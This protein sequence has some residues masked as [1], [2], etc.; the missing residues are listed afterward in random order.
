MKPTPAATDLAALEACARSEEPARVRRALVQTRARLAPSGGPRSADPGSRQARTRIADALL[1]GTFERLV[2]SSGFAAVATGG[3][4]RSE[5]APRSDIDLLLVRRDEADAT[6]LEPF[7]RALWDVGLE[8]GSAVRT[9]AQTEKALASDLSAATATLEGRFLAGDRALFA[10]LAATV[11]RFLE[12]NAARFVRAKVDETTERHAKRGGTIF[13]LAPDLKDGRGTMRDLELARLLAV[14]APHLGHESAERPATPGERSFVLEGLPGADETLARWL[15]LG[16]DR[17]RALARA[18][19][20][21]AATRAA[22]HE[23]DPGSKDQ[24]GKAVQEALAERFGYHERAGRLGVE[25]FLRDVYLAAKLVDRTL[26]LARDRI[27]R[28][29]AGGASSGPRGQRLSPGIVAT[30]AELSLEPRALEGEDGLARAAELFL[31]AQ[32][33]KREVSLAA[34][35]E[36]RRA[37]APEKADEK[38][39]EKLRSDPAVVRA[40]REILR[41]TN[42]V[43]ATLRAMHDAGFLGELLPEL[44][45][46]DCLAQADPYHAYTVDEHTLAAVAA[47]EGEPA[48]PDGGAVLPHTPEREDRIR[49]ELLHRTSRRDLLR[50]G[51]LLHDAGKIG[52]APGHTERGVALVPDVARR[53]GLALDEERHVRFLVEHHLTLSSLVEKRDVDAPATRAELLRF[54]DRSVERLDHLYLLTCADVRAVSPRAF[55][56]WKDTLLTRLY[57][58]AREEAALGP[59]A[60]RPATD[61]DVVRELVPRLPAG[62]VEAD[63]HAHLALCPSPY[64]VE[65]DPGETILHLELLR[66]LARERV[67]FRSLEEDGFDRIYFATRDRPKLF[68]AICG[69]LAACGLNIV[70]ASAFTRRDG[71]ALDRFAV[72]P[73]AGSGETLHPSAER[74]A[75]VAS[76]VSRVLAGELDADALMRSRARRI[77]TA[78]E[79]EPVR[80]PPVRVRLSNKIS[81]K[82]T[83]VDVTAPDRL[84]L[85]HD[86]ACALSDLG[87]DIR[88]AKV[89]TKGDRAIDVFYVTTAEGEKVEGAGALGRIRRTVAA[90][91]KGAPDGDPAQLRLFSRGRSREQHDKKD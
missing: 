31:L 35:E 34:R 36:V 85:L 42:H 25:N 15:D 44:G 12:G 57:E 83:V 65:V 72:V 14:L 90:A 71:I 86:L 47:L 50:L 55:T 9:L 45:A 78:P 74:W 91:A 28:A 20:L 73:A 58:R 39:L 11:A 3:Y 88:L 46:L 64:L 17:A 41:G 8:V 66:S 38:P 89:A 79:A 32:R 49:E 60:I 81:P 56:R 33:T 63:V 37:L 13:L 5:L 22:V 4:G 75:E 48:A 76:T 59:V 6:K 18:D 24:L 80:R 53:L 7:L 29:L 68:G 19:A 82:T 1:R 70:A 2:P 27:M 30:G 84:G 40:L 10:D 23:I 51:L 77:S 52:G 43:A 16:A 26:R 62:I 61:E 21:L 67:A 87:L 69:A 54:C